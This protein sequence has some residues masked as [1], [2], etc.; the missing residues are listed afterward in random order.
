[1]E[2]EFLQKIAEKFGT[3]TYVYNEDQ[4]RKNYRTFLSPFKSRYKNTRIFYAYKANSSLSICH[5]LRQEG[6]GA[7]VVSE[8]ELK[9]AREVGIKPTSIIFTNNSK[10]D[11]ELETAV[12][13]D[14]IINV[15]STSELYRLQKIA[16]SRGK[17]ARVSFRVNPSIDVRTHPK[18]ATALKESKFGIHLENDIAFKA[19]RLAKGLEW[20]EIH[21]VHTHIG[22]QITDTTAFKD[23]AERIM[24]FVHDLKDKLDIKLGFVDLGGGL[25]I[26]YRGED[27]PTPEDLAEAITPVIKKYNTLLDYEPELWLEPGRYIVASSGVL[28]CQVTGVK[29]TPYR[30]FVNLDAGF[31]ALMRPVMYDSYHRV[32]VVNK[33]REKPTEVYD[34]AG[35]ICESGDILAR[36][37][38]LPRIDSGDV[39]A[40]YDAGAYGFSM[41]SQYNLRPRPAE[42]L[43]RDD[44][45]EVI[46]ERETLEDFL[47]HQKVPKD[48]RD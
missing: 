48:L 17:T 20:I 3:P 18:I 19:Y 32:Q 30:K 22:S 2:P 31:N 21:G 14:V 10:T 47:R 43:A 7:D 38:K 15:D 23:A 29:E 45:A 12:D 35:N 5:I 40:I 9:T 33:H 46:R 24:Q 4:I 6:A 13:H 26:P 1:M 11:R 28:L 34:I 42:V 37:R 41:S 25:G 39:I 16:K 44:T 36:E 8:F 27:T